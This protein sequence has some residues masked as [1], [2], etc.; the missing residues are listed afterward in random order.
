MLKPVRIQACLG[1]PPRPF[2]TNDVE[3]RNNVIKQHTNYT[4]QELP[5]FVAKMKDLITKQK[6]EIDRALIGM[7]EY[8]VQSQFNKLVVDKRK[9]FQMSESQRERAL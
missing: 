1:D 9:F 6:E 8:R 4:A 2:Y 5:Q 3:S 7:G